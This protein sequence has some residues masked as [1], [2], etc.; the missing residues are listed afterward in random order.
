MADIFLSYSREDA[1]TANELA[2][3]LDHLGWSVFW[4]RRIPAG[5]SWDEVVEGELRASKCVVVLWSEVSV[6][7]KWV[8]TEANFGLRAGTLVPVALDATDPPIAFQLVEAAQLQGWNGDSQ[9]PEFVVL[10]DG[11]SRHVAPGPLPVPLP[12]PAPVKTQSNTAVPTEPA[13]AIP[14]AVAPK[15]KDPISLGASVVATNEAYLESVCGSSGACALVLFPS[16]TWVCRFGAV[17]VQW[18]DC[19]D[20]SGRC[21]TTDSRSH[22]CDPVPLPGIILASTAGSHESVGAITRSFNAD[23]WRGENCYR[24][25]FSSA[26][27]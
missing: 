23:D 10:T 12:D 22:P 21:R 6:K 19:I 7:S 26:G 24:R 5:S 11:I 4:D 13:V 25:G 9:H 2:R 8:R 14:E 15:R 27:L 20:R 16:G 17:V 3:V 1:K 18:S